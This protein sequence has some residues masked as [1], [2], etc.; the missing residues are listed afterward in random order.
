MLSSIHPLGERV[1]HNRWSVT[2][3]AYVLG[4]AAG[5]AFVGAVAGSIGALFWR[6]GLQVS[7]WVA[8]GTMGIA[9]LLDTLRR[10]PGP[11]RQVN[12]DWLHR[13]RGWVY[14]AGFGFQLGMGVTTIVTTASVYAWIVLAA[15]AADP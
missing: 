6:L 5:G 1:R 10:V 11:R 4:S 8:A 2:V 3:T 13:Y 14:G 12:E 9:L 15:L 7:P